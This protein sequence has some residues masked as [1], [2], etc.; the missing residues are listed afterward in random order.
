MLIEKHKTLP[1]FNSFI[2]KHPSLKS[3]SQMDIFPSWIPETPTLTLL[4]R[5]L[6]P[7]AF[8]SKFPMLWLNDGNA[9]HQITI[10]FRYSLAL[11]DGPLTSLRP[12]GCKTI[13]FFPL[14]EYW[15][16]N[17]PFGGWSGLGFNT[18]SV[19]GSKIKYQSVE[20]ETFSHINSQ[21]NQLLAEL[22]VLDS[23]EEIGDLITVQ[24]TQKKAN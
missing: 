1:N 20:K 4:D 22:S 10:I 17:T 13:V 8:L 5:F 3:H 18:Y 23:L 21:N 9:Q 14:V 6:S 15:R 11:I 12:Y 19:N 2:D 24:S 16:P 7:E